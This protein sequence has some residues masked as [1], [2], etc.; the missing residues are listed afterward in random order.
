MFDAGDISIKRNINKL[1][2]EIKWC[3]FLQWE[4]RSA[5]FQKEVR[6]RETKNNGT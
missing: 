1:H 6:F 3:Y 2:G 5:G 4:F